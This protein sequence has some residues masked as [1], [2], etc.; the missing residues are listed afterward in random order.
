MANVSKRLKR[1]TTT[2]IRVVED[3]VMG[4]GCEPIGTSEK[5]G[6]LGG[7]KGGTDCDGH[8]KDGMVWAR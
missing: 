6:D 1:M 3:C 5:L 2:C 4:N 8:E 7:S